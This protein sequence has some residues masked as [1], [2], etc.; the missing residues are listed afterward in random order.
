MAR[1]P[2]VK[3]ALHLSDGLLGVSL[4]A[5]PA[6]PVTSVVPTMDVVRLAATAMIR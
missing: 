2:A 5:A 3:H 6:E 4:L 1:I